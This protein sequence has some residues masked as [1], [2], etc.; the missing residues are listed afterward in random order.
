MS[1]ESQTLQSPKKFGVGKLKQVAKLV[2]KSTGFVAKLRS[3]R[4]ADLLK[5]SYD[6]VAELCAGNACV[7]KFFSHVQL[8]HV[9]SH[10][11]SRQCR[12]PQPLS[13]E[14]SRRRTD[15][16]IFSNLSSSSTQANVS[17]QT[18]GIHI[19]R[20]RQEMAVKMRALAILAEWRRLEA[21]SQEEIARDEAIRLENE[22]IER[23]RVVVPYIES[24]HPD[25]EELLRACSSRLSAIQVDAEAADKARE[26]ANVFELWG[27]FQDFQL[28][29]AIRDRSKSRVSALQKLGMQ[30]WAQLLWHVLCAAV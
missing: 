18:K 16:A 23:E 10:P 22:R 6:A 21:R 5:D 3:S 29:R 13:Y 11:F 2:A 26:S 17:E 24:R 4:T 28:H 7:H 8:L 15:N 20:I 14:T 25:E 1:N 12:H 27:A 19:G 9:C 30:A